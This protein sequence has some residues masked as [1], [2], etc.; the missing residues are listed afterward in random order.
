MAH[1]SRVSHGHGFHGRRTNRARDVCY[2][3]VVGGLCSTRRRAPAQPTKS[4]TAGFGPAGG[5]TARPPV[6]G[7]GPISKR[8]DWLSRL[9]RS[10]GSPPP[11]AR[12]CSS[13]S[14]A[15]TPSEL[16]CG[17]SRDKSQILLHI[18]VVELSRSKLR[19][20]GFDFSVLA[21]GEKKTVVTGVL[22]GDSLSMAVADRRV[23]DLI[24][25]LRRENVVQVLAEPTIVTLSGRPANF[26][27]G[28]EFPI[29][30]PE[31]VTPAVEFRKYGTMVDVVP[32]L[33]GQGKVG[34]QLRVRISELDQA[35]RVEVGG[36][37][38]PGLR[39]RFVDT[40][41]ETTVGQTVLISG[42]VQD[43]P[44][45]TPPATTHWPGPS[46]TGS[47]ADAKRESIEL[48][49]LVTPELVEGLGTVLPAS[50]PVQLR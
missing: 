18:K 31:G 9:P 38:V 40:W 3:S 13:E 47:D 33:R 32:E 4:R 15:S 36:Q 50:P 11:S 46:E 1:P 17:P 34:I 39:T 7:G 44:V 45:A 24:E 5:A 10:A 20:L 8:P 49:F 41:V 37:S 25:A 27:S 6:A 2:S 35:N 19:E 43:R 16:P 48:L 30:F 29:P 23:L 22:G 12:P 21:D 28:G 14:P 26:H 42:L